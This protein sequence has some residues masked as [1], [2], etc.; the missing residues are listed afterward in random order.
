MSD[1][2]ATLIDFRI[3]PETWEAVFDTKAKY[4]ERGVTPNWLF[5]S[6]DFVEKYPELRYVKEM[7]GMT[8]HIC[9]LPSGYDLMMVHLDD[10]I[11]SSTPKAREE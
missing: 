3:S 6:K 11:Q 1:D 7:S 2:V 5:F 10:D 9:D 4:L 8:V